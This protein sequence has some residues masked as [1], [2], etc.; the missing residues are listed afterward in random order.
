[1]WMTSIF[2]SPAWPNDTIWRHVKRSIYAKIMA[3]HLT[4]PNHYLMYL[5]Y[6]CHHSRIFHISTENCLKNNLLKISF[7]PSQGQWVKLICN[8][9]TICFHDNV[10]DTVFLC[11]KYDCNFTETKTRLGIHQWHYMTQCV[12]YA[13]RLCV[14]KNKK[15]GWDSITFLSTYTSNRRD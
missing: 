9:R 8:N 2:N 12:N 14:P 4:V 6:T 7:K 5:M 13:N 1:M 10:F 11:Y 15:Q 3:C